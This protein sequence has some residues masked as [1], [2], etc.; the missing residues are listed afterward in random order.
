[1]HKEKSIRH[2]SCILVLFQGMYT[3]ITICTGKWQNL[4]AASAPS[5]TLHCIA[6]TKVKPCSV[7]V[8]SHIQSSV[9]LEILMSCINFLQLHV[10]VEILGPHP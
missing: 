7:D 9:V 4:A 2:C 3:N 5:N 8:I 1:M 6:S 10:S